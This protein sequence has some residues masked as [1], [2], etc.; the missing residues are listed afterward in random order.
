MS[1][2]TRPAALSPLGEPD[3]LAAFRLDGEGERLAMLRQLQD[4]GAAVQLSSEG[5][6]HL[7]A[8]LWTVDASRRRLSFSADADEPAL[9]ALLAATELTAVAYLDAVKLQFDVDDAVLVH[10]SGGCT[11]QTGLPTV[12]YRFQ[13]RDAYRVR[14]PERGGPTATLRHPALPDMTLA[15]RVL[16]VSIGG[17]A[18]L[19][20]ADVPPLAPGSEIAGVRLALDADTRFETRLTLQHV[21]ALHGSAQGLRLGCEFHALS[22]AAARTLQRYIDLTQKRR[23]LLSLD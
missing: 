5:G 11:L 23:R 13:R 9:D 10:G 14:T 6:A 4:A 21:S 20:P 3:A 17:C 16:D 2:H 1:L 19:L 7:G 12:L 15:L 18:L 8:T 22:G